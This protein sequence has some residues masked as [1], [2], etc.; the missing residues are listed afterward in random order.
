VSDPVGGW[1]YSADDG[2]LAELE[3]CRPEGIVRAEVD[4]EVWR[5]LF[6]GLL[7][8]RAVL[9]DGLDRPRLVYAGSLRGGLIRV[10]EGRGFVLVRGLDRNLGPWIGVDD[11]EGEGVLRIRGRVGMGTLWSEV[12]VSPNPRY[13]PFVGRLLLLWGSLHLLRLTRPWVGILSSGVS[14][15]AVQ[16]ALERTAV[17]DAR[18]DGSAR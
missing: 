17:W 10:R 7:P 5:V 13:G 2:I 8:L 12:T 14:E 1:A 6:S 18:A 4:D 11:A 16:N 3:W 15:R 9:Q